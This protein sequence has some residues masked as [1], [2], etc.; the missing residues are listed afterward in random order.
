[1]LVTVVAAWFVASQ[2][3][4]RRLIGFICFLLSNVLWTAWGLYASAWALI[5]L[6]GFLAM[7][8]LRGLRR[9][10]AALARRSEP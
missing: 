10:R 2:R 4:Q 3:R 9:N 5:L 1:M 7:T 6:Q 8:N